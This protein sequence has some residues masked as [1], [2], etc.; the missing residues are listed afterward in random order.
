MSLAAALFAMVAKQ[1][2]REYLMWTALS[3]D[4]S[5]VVVLRQLRAEAWETWQVPFII[6]A[7][8]AFLEFAVILF[9]CGMVV[10]LWTLDPVIAIVL[11]VFMAIFL[12]I[13]FA[14]MV[15]PAVRRACPYKSPVGWACVWLRNQLLQLL[16]GDGTWEVHRRA[17]L[18]AKTWARMDLYS[19]TGVPR[20]ATHATADE[21]AEYASKVL[22]PMVRAL[23]W[24][25]KDSEDTYVLSSVDACIKAMHDTSDKL[26][27]PSSAPRRD[28]TQVM[29]HRLKSALF[30]TCKLLELD[31][32]GLRDALRTAFVVVRPASVGLSGYDDWQV[33]VYRT[34]CTRLASLIRPAT[35]D[36]G[37]ASTEEIKIAYR[38]LLSAMEHAIPHM[39]SRRPAL[40][41]AVAPPMP[42]TPISPLS[43]SFGP[44]NDSGYT[45][46]PSAEH[47]A[48]FIGTLRPTRSKV[49][50]P[51]PIMPNSATKTI[52]AAS[53]ECH[54][55]FV[56][57][58]CLIEAI[59][60]LRLPDSGSRK[61]EDFVE[62][63]TRLYRHLYENPDLDG[64]Y[65]GLRTLIF[66][67]L[68][69]FGH[70]ERVVIGLLTDEMI[71][72]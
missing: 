40:A 25:K 38:I 3:A 14:L 53:P 62:C 30:A 54:K 23:S 7:I 29:L 49:T 10:L 66:Q 56:E 18:A 43:T 51:P 47:D 31:H 33:C 39:F 8:P 64:Q 22:V 32:M 72:V 9:L 4:P 67:T 44:E 34:K 57:M 61:A 52:L 15:L 36:I 59:V 16:P 17:Q 58:F 69:R 1:W 37:N 65:L 2:L 68:C 71:S 21:K 50:S 6:G 60:T 13:V 24:V 5:E 27:S 41:Q 45:P 28:P 35:I 12:A 26:I 55:A 11:T 20:Y 63:V 46:R 70:P 48:R 19:V 42:S